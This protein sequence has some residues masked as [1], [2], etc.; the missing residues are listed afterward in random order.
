MPRETNL[1]LSAASTVLIGA[2]INYSF[3]G[4]IYLAICLRYSHTARE[5]V[6]DGSSRDPRAT[7]RMT[8]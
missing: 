4:R 6:V 3:A 1:R 8:R 7:A 2:V 5:P